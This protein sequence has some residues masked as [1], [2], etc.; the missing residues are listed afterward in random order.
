M[1]KPRGRLTCT[2]RQTGN[3]IVG[4]V[5]FLAAVWVVILVTLVLDFA[6][7]RRRGIG[8]RWMATGLLLMN[9]VML[10]SSYA[11]AHSWPYPRT[12]LHWFTL[13]VMTIGLV[14]LAIGLRAMAIELSRRATHSGE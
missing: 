7:I 1:A 6:C 10:V 3:G 14:L 9:G 12:A 2:R 8:W 13:A 4:L 5:I 11:D